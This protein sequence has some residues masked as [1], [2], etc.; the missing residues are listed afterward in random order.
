MV[1]SER[2]T[3]NICNKL[4]SSA[5]SIWNHRTKYHSSPNI[6][7]GKHI[8]NI[9]DVLGKQLV[10][11]DND[12]SLS[13]IEKDEQY[14]CRKCNKIYKYKQ[15]RWFHEKKC[16]EIEIK[17]INHEIIKNNNNNSQIIEN[18]NNGIVNNTI[19]NGTINNI[20]INNYGHEDLSYI[21]DDIIK[22][23][24]E[25]LTH[26]DDAS[27]KNAI[28][29]LARMIHFNPKHKENN[30][31]EINSVRSKTAK[32]M[33]DGKMRHVIKEQLITDIHSK[34]IDFLQNYINKHRLDITR[35]MTECLKHYKLKNP[36]YIKKIILE[37]I[38]LLGYVFYKNNMDID[39]E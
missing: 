6:D 3:C 10:N 31:V 36:E 4:Y 28:P 33:V 22:I 1:K 32:Q 38:N 39:I 23:V 5:S 27:M 19:N 15:S 12:F 35:K 13:Q 26:H 17:N 14:K 37:E 7:Q 16:N 20:T 8:V 9:N 2:Y 11:I 34:I 18:Q 30:N 24:L 25:R 29:R 21:K